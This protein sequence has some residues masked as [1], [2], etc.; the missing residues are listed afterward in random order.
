MA[1]LGYVRHQHIE[2]PCKQLLLVL[3]DL[4][5]LE[6]AS[7]HLNQLKFEP[8]GELMDFSSLSHLIGEA[9]LRRI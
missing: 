1:G 3:H 6:V 9:G 2:V 4:R 8:V 7:L 5:E